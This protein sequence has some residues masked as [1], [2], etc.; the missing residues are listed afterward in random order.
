MVMSRELFYRF[1]LQG[2]IADEADVYDF[3]I[4][5]AAVSKNVI[6]RYFIT[7]VPLTIIRHTGPDPVPSQS[8]EKPGFRIS[9]KRC[10]EWRDY[11]LILMSQSFYTSSCIHRTLTAQQ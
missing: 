9:K 7:A 11:F 10:L 5:S 3:L 8:V 4:K 2:Y 1:R 6:N